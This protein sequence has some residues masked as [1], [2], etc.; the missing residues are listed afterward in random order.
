MQTSLSELQWCTHEGCS[1]AGPDH[2]CRTC[3]VVASWK[4]P[5]PGLREN[6]LPHTKNCYLWLALKTGLKQRKES[7][8]SKSETFLIEPQRLYSSSRDWWKVVAGGKKQPPI[9][10]T[11]D[12]AAFRDWTS[13][14]KVSKSANSEEGTRQHERELGRRKK[15]GN[16]FNCVTMK[17]SLIVEGIYL[18]RCHP[19][20]E[21]GWK[22]AMQEKQIK[23]NKR[24]GITQEAFPPLTLVI[25]QPGIFG[26]LRRFVATV[27]EYT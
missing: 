25:S 18:H 9:E 19:R 1:R 10:S 27:I 16:N 21:Q 11:G 5:C 15:L 23:E 4:G 6:V 2:R 24:N 26:K 3:Q 8:N 13:I 17:I 14:Q 20:S 22:K 12:K 7:L